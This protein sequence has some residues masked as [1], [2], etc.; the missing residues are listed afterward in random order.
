MTIREDTPASRPETLQ[1]GSIT[2]PP[3]VPAPGPVDQHTLTGKARFTTARINAKG[4]RRLSAHRVTVDVPLRSVGAAEAPVAALISGSREFKRRWP[5]AEAEIRMF[6]GLLYKQP[7]DTQGQPLKPGGEYLD[8]D[9]TLDFGS[10][11]SAEAAETAIRDGLGRLLLIDGEFWTPVPEPVIHIGS[12]HEA[13][14][15]TSEGRSDRGAH[16]VFA[17]TELDAAVRAQAAFDERYG[18]DPRPAPV[19]QI[20]MSSAFTKAA[21]AERVQAA[22][23]AADTAVAGLIAGL[24]KDRR[25]ASIY[26]AG[27]DLMKVAGELARQTGEPLLPGSKDPAANG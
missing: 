7:Q 1:P 20:L 16:E 15:I 23:D 14:R 12:G 10:R 26:T 18:F 17:L 3:A 5:K 11:T 27:L 2:V 4:Q 22:R 6:D 21:S 19:V 13:L 8:R 9:I 24:W 25:A